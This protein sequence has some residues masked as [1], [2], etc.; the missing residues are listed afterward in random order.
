M[1]NTARDLLSN[2]LETIKMVGFIP[3]GSRRYYDNRSQPPLLANMVRLYE[4]RTKDQKFVRQPLHLLDIE[5][6]FWMQERSVKLKTSSARLSPFNAM[7]A[8]YGNIHLLNLFRAHTERPRPES[9][10]EDAEQTANMTHDEKIRFYSN[11]A[12]V[13]ESG[14]D[15]SSRW[16][17]FTAMTET[18]NDPE[19]IETKE[20]EQQNKLLQLLIITDLLP[21]DLN[22]VLYQYERTL[23]MFYCRWRWERA[24]YKT[25]CKFYGQQARKRFWVMRAYMY[26]NETGLWSD[27]NLRQQKANNKNE[28]PAKKCTELDEPQI[29]LIHQTSLDASRYDPPSCSKTY[30]SSERPLYV[31]D[32]GSLWYFDNF[33]RTE[34]VLD[35]LKTHTLQEE[36]EIEQEIHRINLRIV[37]DLIRDVNDTSTSADPHLSPMQ[38]M[39]LGSGGIA[40]SN[41]YSG[42]QWDQ[43]N[44]WAP[45]QHYVITG[46]LDQA[47]RLAK[48]SAVEKDPQI[49]HSETRQF[50]ENTGLDKDEVLATHTLARKLSRNWLHSNY[51]GWFVK[52][53]L[54]EKYDVRRPGQAGS[55]GEYIV[56]EGFGWTNGVAMR[57]AEMYGA[58]RMIYGDCPNLA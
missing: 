17:N 12:S 25:K 44:A 9:F 2:L 53:A 27:Y 13:A 6:E 54:Y 32:I 24:D 43:P 19:F 29:R 5:Y 57:L 51:C 30:E 21:F 16:M 23:Q 40:I 47:D 36:E 33:W 37:R 26:D 11:T 56:Q 42:Q 18:L 3:N 50:L 45:M 49:G 22:G 52:T 41:V 1:E 35:S 58:H 31:T 14:W 15:F 46:L 48:P 38:R 39:L 10:Y 34:D 20:D 55:G 4:E 8:G 28:L 7:P